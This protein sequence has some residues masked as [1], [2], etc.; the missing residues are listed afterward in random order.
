ML[1][2]NIHVCLPPAG[3]PSAMQHVR[4][5]SL[6]ICSLRF[7]VNVCHVSIA[8]QASGRGQ[9]YCRTAPTWAANIGLHSQTQC[10]PAKP[11][12]VATGQGKKWF[13]SM[14]A[15]GFLPPALEEAHS[16]CVGSEQV[17]LHA[18]RPHPVSVT[19]SF[20]PILVGE[21][22]TSVQPAEGG[23][24]CIHDKVTFYSLFS[25]SRLKKF[26]LWR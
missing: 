10:Q 11:L 26:K 4:P 14:Q 25:N 1:E 5:D 15:S 16:H 20:L 2:E 6:N 24:R 3:V 13:C 12:T 18:N 21:K 7:D 9:A 8:R 23:H 19:A 22:D 17:I